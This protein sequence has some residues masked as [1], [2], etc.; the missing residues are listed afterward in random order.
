MQV[1]P[2]AYLSRETDAGNPGAGYIRV[3][4]VGPA[5]ETEDALTRIRDTLYARG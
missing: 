4:L 2:G 5:A 3:A 1:L